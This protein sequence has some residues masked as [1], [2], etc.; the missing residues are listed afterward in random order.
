MI[1]LILC[2]ILIIYFLQKK[3]Q[4]TK[5]DCIFII[6]LF[7]SYILFPNYFQQEN[8]ESNEAIQTLAGLYNNG[9]L[10]VPSLKLTGDLTVAGNSQLASL[11]VAGNS[12]LTDLAVAKNSQLLNLNVRSGASFANN[13]LRIDGDTNTANI[14]STGALNITNGNYVA[15]FGGRVWL[16]AIGVPGAG[17]LQIDKG[18]T[19]ESSKIGNF[20]IKNNI[21]GDRNFSILNKSSNTGSRLVFQDDGNILG[22]RCDGWTSGGFTFGGTSLG[23]TANTDGCRA[24]PAGDDKY[25]DS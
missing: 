2:G 24:K 19:C 23:W 1:A 8:F 10:T 9:T 18:L 14:S 20:S 13:G 15:I 11:A 3:E 17:T 4:I 21:V 5:Y 12:Q 7:V 22:R 6:L 16:P 25:W